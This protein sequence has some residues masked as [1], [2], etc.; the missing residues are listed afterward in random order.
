MK[1]PVEILVVL[2]LLVGIFPAQTVEPL[3]DVAAR[4]VLQGP[5]PEHDLAIWHG[6]SPAL[7]MSVIAL[8]GGVLLYL[9]RKPLFALQARMGGRLDARA[10]YEHGL[11]AVLG[12]AGKVLMRLEA[13][14]LQQQAA[15]LVSVALLLGSA[16]MMGAASPLTGTRP[17][18]PVDGVS[19]LA[20]LALIGATLAVTVLHRQRLTALIVVG[21]VGLIVAL[22]FVKFSAP[23]LALT[24]LSVEVVTI[25]LLL[26]ALY[27]L[28]AET[29]EESPEGRRWRD[30]CLAVLAGGGAAL[31]AWAV[32]TRPDRSI[33]GWF[34]E[35]SV[36][37]GGGTNVVNVILVDF[38]GFDTFGEISVL[39]IAALGIFALLEKLRLPAPQRDAAG[40]RWDVDTHPLIMATF[41]RL[42][43]PLARTVLR[44]VHFEIGQLL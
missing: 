39:A 4:A 15:I 3:L 32:L 8:I 29:P 41:S 13:I 28:P 36:T 5:L 9:G 35:N 43:L 1:V 40:H 31:L 2:C 22:A 23:D 18:L 26:L 12:L 10:I 27:F 38:R 16:G 30:A 19:L 34:L 24:Q 6:F 14:G 44:E 42:L 37:G 21:A 20:T 33:A 11:E 17:L 25:I 7:W